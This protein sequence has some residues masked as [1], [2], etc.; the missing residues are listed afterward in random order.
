MR[1]PFLRSPTVSIHL[2]KFHRIISRPV[3]TR[4]KCGRERILSSPI[5]L[6]VANW[7]IGKE[8]HATQQAAGISTYLDKI[9]TY[10]EY[11]VNAWSVERPSEQRNHL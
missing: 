11:L 4:I 7:C 3:G 1:M 8:P 2:R 9:I 5:A 6:S 10:P